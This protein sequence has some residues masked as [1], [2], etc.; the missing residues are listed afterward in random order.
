MPNILSLI[1]IVPWPANYIPSAACFSRLSEIL[2]T[3]YVA[4]RFSLILALVSISLFPNLHWDHIAKYSTPI[5]S[6]LRFNR[7]IL[8]YST[9]LECTVQYCTTVP[10]SLCQHLSSLWF[11]GQTVIVQRS[12]ASRHAQSLSPLCTVLYS[13][14]SLQ[15]HSTVQCTSSQ[16]NPVCT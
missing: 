11:C 1:C 8:Q 2:M 12:N 7:T 16:S 15:Y 13:A 9:V 5:S 14:L 4:S 6:C 10:S 3:L